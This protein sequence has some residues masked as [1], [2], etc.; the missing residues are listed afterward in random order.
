MQPSD[1]EK[2]AQLCKELSMMPVDLYHISIWS[3]RFVY[4][5][6][7]FHMQHYYKPAIQ[8]IAFAQISKKEIT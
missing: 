8:F 7:N 1:E 6:C 4:D 5:L 3:M 2:V